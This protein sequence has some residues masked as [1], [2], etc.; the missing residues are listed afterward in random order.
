MAPLIGID[1]TLTLT[2]NSVSQIFNPL[3]FA[4]NKE[5]EM[6][7]ITDMGD[8]DTWKRWAPGGRSWTVDITFRAD[9]TE[10]LPPIGVLMVFTGITKSG[11]QVT[12]SVWSQSV[13]G[14]TDKNGDALRTLHCVGN[15]Q[16]DETPNPSPTGHEG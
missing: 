5:V 14:D 4:Y 16:P 11:I 10:H 3:S 15:G 9:D 6:H 12:G 7:D 8:T 1:A 2:K 13:G